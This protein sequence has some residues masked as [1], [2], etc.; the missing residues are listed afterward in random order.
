M[1][2][3]SQQVREWL[4]LNPFY[5]SALA[6]GIVNNSSL[7]RKIRPAIE[8]TQG[9]VVSEAAVKMALHRLE[10]E[11]T[12]VAK[13]DFVKFIGDLTIQTG[14]RIYRLPAEQDD[15]LHARY[16]ATDYLVATRGTKS[17]TI[18]TKAVQPVADTLPAEYCLPEEKSLSAITFS[19][20]QGHEGAPGLLAFVLSQIAYL[21]INA[22][23]VVSALAE[24]TVVLNPQDIDEVF[25]YFHNLLYRTE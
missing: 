22:V 8:Q 9:E 2:T 17:M 12:R 10:T 6:E 11:L 18:I 24:L 21:N 19:F 7:A 4:N 1:I 3:I 20:R 14:L 23:E 15:N 13:V 16:R 5:R 25:S